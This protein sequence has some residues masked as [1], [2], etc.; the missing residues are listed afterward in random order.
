M[1]RPGLLLSAIFALAGCA[2]ATPTTVVEGVAGLDD[3]HLL[4]VAIT[5]AHHAAIGRDRSNFWH[6][7]KA[8]AKQMDQHSGL[9]Q[10]ALRRELFGTRAWTLSVWKDEDSLNRFY[11]SRVH[12]QAM[13]VATDGLSGGKFARLQIPASEI[14]ELSWDRA[15]LAIQKQPLVKPR[16]PID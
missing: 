15:L 6:H 16:A 2:I 13:A 14:A 8:V 3:D 7:T 1:L 11:W 4:T 10:Y 9:V 5:E 12:A